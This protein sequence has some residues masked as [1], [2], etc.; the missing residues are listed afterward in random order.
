MFVRFPVYLSLLRGAFAGFL[1][2]IGGC[3]AGKPPASS[4]EPWFEDVTEAAGLSFVHVRAQDARFL[5]P[6]I[7]SGGAAWLDYDGDGL[8]DLYLVQGGA[9]EP[10]ASP[11]PMNR[12]YRNRGDGTFT[13]VTA[14]AEVG[15]TGYGM[16]CAVMDY[17]NDGDPDLYVTNVG[18][19]RLFRN[20]GNGT[21]F[22]VTD[23]AGVG[24]AGWGA[25]ATFFDYDADGNPDLFVVNY[26]VWS[27]EQE[28]K[29][30]TGGQQDYCMPANYN[31]PATDVLYRNTG[32]GSFL[33]TTREAGLQ[34]A[35]GN[36]LGVAPG[37]YDG[38]GDV[39]LYVANDGLPNQLWINNGD[40]TFTDRGLIT[41]TAVNRQGRAE[42][43][44][45]VLSADFDG[46][47]EL[48]LFLTHLRDETNTL[49][50]NRGGFFE[51][52]TIQAG[53]AAPSIQ[54]TGFGTGAADFD[55]DGFLDLYIANGRVGRTRSAEGDDPFGEPDHLFL[56]REGG[57]FEQ[58]PPTTAF[59]MPVSDNSRSA[60][61]GDYDNDGDVDVLVVTNGGRPHLL[62]NNA[63]VRG[64]WIQFQVVDEKGREATGAR[65]RL[66][67]T[68]PSQARQVQRTYSY[69]ASN[70]PRVHFGLG[71]REDVA[72]VE[73]Y[74]PGGTAEMFGPFASNAVYLLQK[75]KGLVAERVVTTGSE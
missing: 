68:K 47:G 39:D 64:R 8:L 9:L 27:P 48:D 59:S 62:R 71:Q 75:G 34:E 21:F 41:G 66:N 3:S 28:I 6:E 19:N 45:G 18:K 69:Q 43:S 53:L 11:P 17:D 65:L 2:L 13:D 57:R 15:D 14:S 20:E 31:A 63:G 7:M 54:A 58:V 72:G 42:A 49:Y 4:E 25:S 26:V 67:G 16:G 51:E 40:G 44:M 37:D 50:L 23:R 24:D 52:V 55:H 33:E 12:L 74:W 29:C 32:D 56:G 30:Y 70:D 35:K 5:F 61:F 46:N 73:V 10:E 60:A 38:D 36:G 1:C 22:D